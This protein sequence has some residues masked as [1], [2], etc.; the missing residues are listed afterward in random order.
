M[1]I[2][3]IDAIA[4]GPTRY[5]TG[6]VS[7]DNATDLYTYS[8]VVNNTSRSSSIGELAL[9]VDTFAHGLQADPRAIPHAVPPGFRV[10]KAVSGSIEEPPYN[11]AGKL[12]V[13]EPVNLVDLIQ[14]GQT[15]G[16]FSFS[17]P[18]PP[19]VGQNNNYFLYSFDDQRVVDYGRVVAPDF[20]GSYVPEPAAGTLASAATF[21]AIA[22]MR[23]K[24]PK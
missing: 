18:F 7:F 9:L 6:S 14:A 16:G 10:H 12:F 17:A 15:L 3:P 8:Y 13:W 19:A 24:R 5:L 2:A 1:A 22:R 23:H 4:V 20:R 21:V 11:I